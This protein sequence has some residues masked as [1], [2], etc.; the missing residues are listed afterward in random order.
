MPATPAIQHLRVDAAPMERSLSQ[1]IREEREDLK[2]AA[3]QTLNLV[4]DL[5]LKGVIKWVSGSWKDVVGTEPEDVTGKPIEELLL[6]EDKEIFKQAVE[7]MQKD[8]SKSQII[9]FTVSLGPASKLLSF[10]DMESQTETLESAG[11]P[12]ENNS[13]GV[14]ELEAQGIMVYD[15]SSEEASQESHVGLEQSHQKYS[16]FAYCA[17]DNVD[18]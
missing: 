17:T 11:A 10:E 12:A 15:R 14:V 4:M 9:R 6:D 13:Y 3:E 16:V 18:D 2:E 8:D 5:D 7:S 1:D